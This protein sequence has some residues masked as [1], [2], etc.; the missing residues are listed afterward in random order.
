MAEPVVRTKG[1]YVVVFE[2]GSGNASDFGSLADARAGDVIV[3]HSEGRREISI[4]EKTLGTKWSRRFKTEPST[5]YEHVL[6]KSVVVE[7]AFVSEVW[8]LPSGERHRTVEEILD[9]G[10]K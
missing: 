4:V 5:Y 9:G 8:R 6:K 3:W 2:R 1:K 7:A 10:E